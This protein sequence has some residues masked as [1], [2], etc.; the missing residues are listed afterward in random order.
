MNE[1]KEFQNS[2]KNMNIELAK[3]EMIEY[4]ALKQEEELEKI[5]R[6]EENNKHH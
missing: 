6:N 4:V 2:F 5:I 3:T 1:F